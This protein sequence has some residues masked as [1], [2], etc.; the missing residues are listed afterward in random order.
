MAR[1]T[2]AG[3]NIVRNTDYVR[4][5]DTA[6]KAELTASAL[7]SGANSL[8]C[9]LRRQDDINLI[10]A[11]HQAA[12]IAITEDFSERARLLVI[13]RRYRKQ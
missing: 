3:E 13:L 7:V 6:G 4:P 12:L 8:A 2:T 10:S 11:Q 9:I 5:P 1:S